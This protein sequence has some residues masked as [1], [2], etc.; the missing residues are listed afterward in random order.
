VSLT[1][2]TVM[3]RTKV[4]I[5]TWF[6]AALLVTSLTPGMS[7]LQLQKMLGIKRGLVEESPEM[8]I[9]VFRACLTKGT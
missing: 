5:C 4:P 7:A 9:L 8:T 1:A 2:N 6:Y 3:H